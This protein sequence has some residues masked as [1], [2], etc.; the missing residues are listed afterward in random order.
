MKASP[1]QEVCLTF[2]G[3]TAGTVLISVLGAAAPL[4]G[5][6]Q[7]AVAGLFMWTA[8][9]M[10]QREP[11]GLA[12]FGLSLGG[13][14]DSP[15]EQAVGVRATIVD[16]A[17][18]LARATPPA[19]RELGAAI[20]VAAVIFPPFVAGFYVFHSPGRAF[21]PHLPDHFASYLLSQLVVVG[22][23]EEALFRGYFMGRLSDHFP[24]RTRVL[25]AQ[26]ALPALL[27]QAALFSLI[28]VAVDPR[29][30][31]LAVFFPGL[32]FGWLRARRGGIGA[33]AALHACCNLLSDVL[34]RGWL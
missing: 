31:R 5:Y 34:V 26:L 15:E 17:R 22:L 2:A 30:A 10:S 9:H 7:L 27:G 6:V 32:L 25:G 13:L 16:L 21:T 29:P 19:L 18:A 4:D 23:P 28:H 3:V 8:V 11:D 1:V 33:S 24:T 14:L 20:V 12:R